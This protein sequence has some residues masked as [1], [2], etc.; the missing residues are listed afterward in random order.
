MT[1]LYSKTLYQLYQVYQFNLYQ[2]VIV[3][4]SEKTKVYHAKKCTTRQCRLWY[5]LENGTLSKKRTVP[6]QP[7]EIRGIGTVGTLGTVKR[8]CLKSFSPGGDE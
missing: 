1:R 7:I 5:T 2:H 6:Q 4:H 3:V 8:L